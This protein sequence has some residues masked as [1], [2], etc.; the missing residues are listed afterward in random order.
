MC[1]VLLTMALV[2]ALAAVGGG[3]AAAAEVKLGFVDL[4]RALNECDA[5]KGARDRFLGEMEAKQARLR[6]E[7]EALDSKR[8]EFDKK[9]MLLREKERQ[10]MEQQL[11]DQGLAF[12]R[13]YEDYQ[14]ELKRMDSEYTG[15]ILKDLETIIGTVGAEGG[16]T[17][18]FEMQNS[19]IVYGDPAA[20]L[21]EEVIRRYNSGGPKK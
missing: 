11:E 20:D 4:Q 6:K 21:T 7:K 17:V 10:S 9:A 3:R 1:R 16:Y 18:I 15:A 14:K 12:K 2:L 13:K 8:E 5:G 19:G